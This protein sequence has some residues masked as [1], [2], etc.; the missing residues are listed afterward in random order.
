MPLVASVARSSL[1]E[2]IELQRKN[3]EWAVYDID[4]RKRLMLRAS[5]TYSMGTVI[6]GRVVELDAESGTFELRTSSDTRVD[7]PPPSQRLGG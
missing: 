5:D 1:R 3:S 4:T 2:R 7:E 6:E